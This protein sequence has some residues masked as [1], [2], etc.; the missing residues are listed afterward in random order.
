MSG[1]PRWWVVVVA[2]L[3]VASACSGEGAAAERAADQA[4]RLAEQERRPVDREHPAAETEAAVEAATSID[5]ATATTGTPATITTLQ[6]TEPAPAIDGL[7]V[8]GS[9]EPPLPA[10]EPGKVSVVAANHFSGRFGDGY[11]I[12]VRNNTEWTISGLE[13]GVVFRGLDGN[14]IGTTSAWG[15]KPPIVPPGHVAWS[16]AWPLPGDTEADWDTSD[17]SFTPTYRTDQRSWERPLAVDELQIENDRVTA[18]I[19][20]PYDVDAVLAGLGYL[21]ITV[22]GAPMESGHD[23]ADP[24]DIPSEASAAAD[25]LL[26]AEC[27]VVLVTASGGV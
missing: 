18:V 4:R 1:G 20:N 25:L 12:V 19:R 16:T 17:P 27:P 15:F 3:V 23:L 5:V 9:E 7:V 14:L 13:V 6:S 11:S 10:G 24:S 2:A 21:C 8:F 26:P 22:E